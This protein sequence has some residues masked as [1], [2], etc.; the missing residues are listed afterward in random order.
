M[1]DAHL[2]RRTHRQ[3]A[4]VRGQLPARQ[5]R[6]RAPARRPHRDAR[7]RRASGRGGG[8]AAARRRP[9]GARAPVPLPDRPRDDRISR[10]ASSMPAKTR[11]SAASANCSRK[12]ATPPANGRMPARCTWRSPTRPRSSTS[13]SRAASTLGRAPARPRRVPRRDHGH[14]GRAAGLVPRRHRDRRQDADLHAVAA[15]RPVGRMGARLAAGAPSE[16]CRI[17]GA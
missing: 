5:A 16:R 13:T 4:A 3:R 8:R 15:E 17:I 14:A 6:H 1:D 2:K 7:I 9:R 12:P 10:P 11:C